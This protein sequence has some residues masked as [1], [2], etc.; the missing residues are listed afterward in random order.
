MVRLEPSRSR[1]RKPTLAAKH[2][3]ESIYA[4]YQALVSLYNKGEGIYGNMK[5]DLEPSLGR[6]ADHLETFQAEGP[7][8]SDTPGMKWM[9][10][11]VKAC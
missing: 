4:A 9:E 6:L 11:F 10:E 3:Y 2:S 8:A 7:D 1:Q 5:I